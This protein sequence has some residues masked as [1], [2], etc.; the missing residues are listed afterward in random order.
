MSKSFLSTRKEGILGFPRFLKLSD[1]WF[2]FF[3][4]GD[5]AL[6]DLQPT[7]LTCPPAPRSPHQSRA[8]HLHQ[9]PGAMAAAECERGLC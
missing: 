7:L 1:G 3:P 4:T 5:Y 9:Q 6:G 8:A 2:L